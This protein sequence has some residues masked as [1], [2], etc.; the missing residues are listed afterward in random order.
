MGHQEIALGLQEFW[1]AEGCPTIPTCES[2]PADG[3]TPEVFFG[4]LSREPFSVCQG[5]NSVDL[6]LS[7]CGDDPLHPIVD[8]RLQVVS[9]GR[10]RDLRERFIDSLRALGFDLPGR[11]VRFVPMDPDRSIP[12]M[13]S[14]CWNVLIDRIEVGD[15]KRLKS[16]GG[17]DLREEGLMAEYSLS[18]LE[19]CLQ[20]DGRGSSSER[21]GQMATYALDCADAE[22]LGLLFELSAA[23][24]EGAL[25]HG[26]YY[27]AYGHA[28]TCMHLQS[29]L[30]Q[31]EEAD[32]GERSARIDDLIRGCARA[33]VEAADA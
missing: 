7:P 32:A 23:E 24:C 14:A 1:K 5:M 19:I 20:G 4:I 31:R 29:L 13:E 11:D 16:L 12:W 18:R 3:M 25:A 22:R 6:E 9:Q 10:S 21:G 26:L 33:Y 8:H 28:L 27:P 17:I 2:I 30:H 15:V